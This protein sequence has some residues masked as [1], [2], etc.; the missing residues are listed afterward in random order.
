MVNMSVYQL[1]SQITAHLLFLNF[2]IKSFTFFS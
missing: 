2:L 1:K